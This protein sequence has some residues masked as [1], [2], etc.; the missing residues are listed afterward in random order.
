[1]SVQMKPRQLKQLLRREAAKPRPP[2][3]PQREVPVTYTPLG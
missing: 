2:V 1:M 3:L